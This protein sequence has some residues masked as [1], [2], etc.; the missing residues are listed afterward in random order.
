MKAKFVNEG[1]DELTI[2]TEYKKA[3]QL[4]LSLIDSNLKT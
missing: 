4:T 3:Y 1:N 2:R